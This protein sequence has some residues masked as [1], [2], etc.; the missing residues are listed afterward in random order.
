LFSEFVGVLTLQVKFRLDF[1]GSNQ[2]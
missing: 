2:L 1:A